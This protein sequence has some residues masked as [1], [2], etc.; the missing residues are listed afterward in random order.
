[1][2]SDS[3][4]PH[5][6]WAEAL[7]TAVYLRN[8]SP[9]KGLQ[10]ITPFEAW[11]GVK[12]DVSSLRI[13][14]CCAYAHIPKVERN[15]LDPKTRKCVLLGYGEQRKGYRLYD[16]SCDRV[17]YSRDVVFNETSV[18]GIQKEQRQIEEK[19]VELE[20]EDPVSEDIVVS[21]P[22]STNQGSSIEEVKG[23]N[24]E[25]NHSAPSAPVTMDPPVRRSTRI[26]HPPERY[27]YSLAAGCED[28]DPSSVSEAL[29]SHDKMKW[30]EA[31]KMEMQ[32]LL[33]NEVWELVEPPSNRKIIGSK[34]IFRKK[35]DANGD[36]S[37]YK[38]RL[39]AQGC[40][41]RFGLDYEETFSPVVCFESVQSVISLG[42]QNKMHLH[43]MDVT[44]AF[45]HGELSERKYSWSSQRASLNQERNILCADSKEAYMGS[46]KHLIAG[47][48]PLTTV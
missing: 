46:S 45:L 20:I 37:R 6:F 33:A 38:A 12:P 24:I 17:F 31:M 41:Q 22:T 36:I 44:T 43:Q 48:M 13:F 11:H 10:G 27:E 3:K 16:P 40:S 34:W 47:T 35:T 29:S 8:R 1:M 28:Q 23:T 7:S 26:R 14:G 4:L 9:T 19:Y 32:S 42:V 15:K 39:V 5:R 21:Y 30:E 25:V 18:P 2:L